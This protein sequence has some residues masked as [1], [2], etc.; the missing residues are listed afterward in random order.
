[1]EELVKYLNGHKNYRVSTIE[2]DYLT[3]EVKDTLTKYSLTLKEL[4]YR[5]IHNIALDKVF[6]CKYCGKRVG[7]RKGKNKYKEFCDLKCSGDYT[8]NLK[9]VKEKKQQTLIEK[10]GV[11]NPTKLKEFKIKIKNTCLNKYGVDHYSK[12]QKWKDRYK[13]TCNK[14]YGTDYYLQSQERKNRNDEM[15]EKAYNTKKSNNT[16]N[17]SKQEEAVYKLLLT[18]FQSD[19]IVRYYKSKLYPFNCDFYIKSLDLYI[20]YNGNWTHGKEPFDKNNLKHLKLLEYWKIKSKETN[21]KK[22]TKKYY[23]SAIYTWTVRDV[24]KLETFKKNKLN[25]KIFWNIEEV[26]IWIKDQ[27]V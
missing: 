10:Y 2:K 27:E 1:M 4:C 12:T 22:K 20:E 18:K 6:T 3:Q 11:N 16:C 14:R 9:E 21:F 13:Q 5:I 19:D 26:K 25:Y 23:R 7:L 24:K 15:Q 8:N 17:T